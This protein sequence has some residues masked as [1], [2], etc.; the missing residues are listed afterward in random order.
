MPV[1]KL[2]SNRWR[3]LKAVD[4]RQANCLH[5]THTVTV[6][7]AAAVRIIAVGAVGA[8]V[9]TNARVVMGADDMAGDAGD[10]GG[11][12]LPWANTPDF[13]LKTHA[14]KL[15]ISIFV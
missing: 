8:I 3:P 4:A 7:G 12:S 5:Q 15:V 9:A 2:Q 1:S 14:M 6:E 13:G 11:A 10:A